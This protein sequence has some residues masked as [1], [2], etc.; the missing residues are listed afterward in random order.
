MGS[1]QGP[2]CPPPT[3]F[4]QEG[5]LSWAQQ[6]GV[7]GVLP[8]SELLTGLVGLSRPFLGRLSIWGHIWAIF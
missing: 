5:K 7:L 1:R 8:A 6:D 3:A 2:A 4:P